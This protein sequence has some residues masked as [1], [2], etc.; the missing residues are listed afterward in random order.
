MARR[1]AE[2]STLVKRASELSPDVAGRGTDQML[3]VLAELSELFPSGGLRRGSTVSVA[4]GRSPGSTSLMLALLAAASETG[5]WVAV[6]GVPDLGVLA[7]AELGIA[8]ERLAL[9]PR[10]GVMFDKV[11]ATLLDGFDIVV[12]TPQGMPS[13]GVRG[14]LAARARQHGSVLVPFGQKAWEGA[15]IRLTTEGSV[16][17]GLGRGRGRLRSRELTVTA[18]GRGAVSRPRTVKL[19]LPGPAVEEHRP[20][21]TVISG[22]G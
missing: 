12:A 6:V 8:L 2:L 10:P 21:L 17:H 19:W 20:R 1:L 16:W 5:S 18:R 13:A 14:Q 7:A 22:S 9:V 11:V 3:P 4:P 15:D